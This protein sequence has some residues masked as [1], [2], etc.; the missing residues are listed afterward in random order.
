MIANK[1]AFSLSRRRASTFDII[2]PAR[3]TAQP[4]SV[5]CVAAGVMVLRGNVVVVVVLPFSMEVAPTASALHLDSVMDQMPSFFP[6][7]APASYTSALFSPFPLLAVRYPYHGVLP[8]PPSLFVLLSLLCLGPCF[9]EYF[10]HFPKKTC[11]SAGL[12]KTFNAFLW[13]CSGHLL[14][15]SY[16]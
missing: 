9:F 8:C 6:A 1:G 7:T 5:S 15:H 4:E 16:T 2:T 11:S 14:T 13:A 3:A 10:I 12:S